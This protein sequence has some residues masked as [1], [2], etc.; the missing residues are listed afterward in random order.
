ME[1]IK[2]IIDTLSFALSYCIW[3]KIVDRADE[4]LRKRMSDRIYEIVTWSAI[5]IIFVAFFYTLFR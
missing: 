2:T 5:I 1:I 4:F 3:R